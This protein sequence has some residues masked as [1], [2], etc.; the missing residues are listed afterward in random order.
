M[1]SLLTHPEDGLLLRYLDGELPGR[2]SRQVRGH[3]EACW[4]CRASVEDLEGTISACVQ[5]RN[6]ALQGH[7]PMPPVPWADLSAGFARVD[8]ELAQDRW[9]ARLGRRLAAPRLQRWAMAAAS[10]ALVAGGIYYQVLHTP[11]VQAATL[12]RRAVAVTAS[13]S[14]PAKPVRMRGNY[15]DRAAIPAMLRVAHYPAGDPLSPAA[16]QQ[17][18]GSLAAKHDEVTSLPNP[19]RPM[20]NCFRIRTLAVE[21]DLAAASLTISAIDYRPVATRFEFRDEEWVE[22]SEISDGSATDGGTPAVTRLDAPTRRVVPSRPAALP[23]GE[24]ASISE[25]LRVLAALHEIGADLG[26]PL[27]I[28]RANGQVVVSGVG[29]PPARQ[30]DIHRALDRLP[31]VT[32]HFSE[33]SPV[34]APQA[35]DAGEVKPETGSRSGIPARLEQ[36]LGSRAVFERFSGQALDAFDNAM[37]HAYALRSLAQRFPEGTAMSAA[38]SAVLADLARSHL[39]ILSSQIDELHRTLAPVLVSLGGSPAQGRPAVSARTWQTAAEESLTDARRVEVLLSTLF[40]MTDEAPN[41]H[42][43]SDLLAAFASL[44]SALENCQKL[45]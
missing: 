29:I 45:L 28:N 39:R 14:A 42:V 9:G 16:F 38:D 34:A 41:A 37:A 22:Y 10:V 6:E 21:G 33:P 12:I 30:S 23:S 7:L 27:E 31:R 43:P 25:E 19:Q 40:G 15:K 2:K 5:Y 44:R 20:E 3:L 1:S 26:D 17:W 18:R 11:S 8:R 13:K 35:A 32:V 36:Q 4:Q 24:P